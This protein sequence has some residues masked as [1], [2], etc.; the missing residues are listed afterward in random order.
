MRDGCNWRD[1]R[2][3]PSGEPE[4]TSPPEARGLRRDEVRLLVSRLR[5]ESIEHARF[6]DLP[7]WLSAGDLLVV[8]TS[9]TLNAALMARRRRERVRVAPVDGASRRFLDG[10][11][12]ARQGASLPYRKA[13]AGAR[14][15]LPEGG[16]AA[17]LAPYPLVD[18]VN[19]ESRL[20]IA[21]LQ[22]PG[23]APGISIE[24]DFRFATS[25]SRTAGPRRCTRPCSR[26][27]WQR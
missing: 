8:N 4:A 1:R 24:M 5:E 27:A 20:W 18:T 26:R 25:T 19:A 13:L 2:L 22:L 16:E 11:S 12:R 15:R 21:A 17:L 23:A 10:R 14:Y 7:R 9:G 6:H 3:H